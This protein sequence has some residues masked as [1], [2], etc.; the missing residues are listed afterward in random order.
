MLYAPAV[1]HLSTTALNFGVVHVGQ[2][3]SQAVTITNTATG[4]LTDSLIGGFGTVTGAFI[5]S[6]TLNAT[7]GAAGTLTV[8]LNTTAFGVE[9]GSATLALSSPCETTSCARLVCRIAWSRCAMECP[10]SLSLKARR[11]IGVR[12]VCPVNVLFQER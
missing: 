4:A 1:A 5:G 3:V 2:S 8:G 9:A 11:S 6:G 7:V 12:R 10:R